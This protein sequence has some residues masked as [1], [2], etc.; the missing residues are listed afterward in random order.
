ML[1]D[2]LELYALGELPEDISAVVE[3]H[4]QVCVECGIQVEESRVTI[5]QC[6]AADEPE[7]AGPEKR[8][9]SRVA[10]DDPAFLTILKPERSPRITMRIVDTSIGGLKLQLHRQLMAGT[11]IQ[12]RV[13]ELFI[14]GEV[15]YCIPD[16]SHFHA[17]VRI[18]DVFQL[19][20][21]GQTAPPDRGPLT[22]S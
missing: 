9:G 13:R 22:I 8:K 17:G 7:Y 11:I 3:S 2:Q 16:D 5:G 12:V 18:Q 14:L 19:S 1:A 15:R 10:T 20:P 4:L 21:P 6:V